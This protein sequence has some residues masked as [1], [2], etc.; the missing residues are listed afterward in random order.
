V[1]AEDQFY[2]SD[3][4]LARLRY[5]LLQKAATSGP[6]PPLD[7]ASLG[8][9]AT[10]TEFDRFEEMLPAWRKRLHEFGLPSDAPAATVITAGS[11]A[12]LGH[13]IAAHP[14]TDFW[15]PGPLLRS[16]KPA[17]SHEVQPAAGGMFLLAPNAGYFT[18]PRA[19]HL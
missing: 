14:Q 11:I 2:G 1:G 9:T 10:V 16:L 12:D 19:C 15:I 5:A 3:L 7:F 18:P 6:P 13:L 17:L 8:I 4:P